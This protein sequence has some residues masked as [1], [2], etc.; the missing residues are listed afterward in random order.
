M[1]K[2]YFRVQSS[3][4]ESLKQKVNS[5]SWDLL[6]LNQGTQKLTNCFGDNMDGSK[7]DLFLLL[8]RFFFVFVFL[9]WSSSHIYQHDYD[10]NKSFLLLILN[11]KDHNLFKNKTQF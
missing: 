7:W 6:K 9:N 11:I 3:L 10:F 1:C 5:T 2:I 8:I 4:G